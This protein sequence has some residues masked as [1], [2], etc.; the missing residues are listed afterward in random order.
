MAL[1]IPGR[2]DVPP[3]QCY[4]I[5]SRDKPESYLC[6]PISYRKSSSRI[7]DAMIFGSP[8]DASNYLDGVFSGINYYVKYVTIDFHPKVREDK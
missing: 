2:I 8:E 4:V 6:H 1:I 5:A 7:A 3:V